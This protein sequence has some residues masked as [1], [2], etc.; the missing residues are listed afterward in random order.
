MKDSKD[1]TRSKN[2]EGLQVKQGVK[3]TWGEC[4]FLKA[5]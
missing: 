5:V 4:T 3:T 1:T 2:K